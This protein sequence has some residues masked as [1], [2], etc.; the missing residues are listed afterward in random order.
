MYVW[1]KSQY[2]VQNLALMPKEAKLSNPHSSPEPLQDGSQSVNVLS[3]EA[4]CM[5]DE[6]LNI[7]TSHDPMLA[8]DVEKK[9]LSGRVFTKQ[10]A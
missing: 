4:A 7:P 6:I 5:M 9:P 1:L 10:Q 8:H 3:R 2:Q